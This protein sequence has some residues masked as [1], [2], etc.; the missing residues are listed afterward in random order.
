MTI[1]FLTFH[2]VYLN[3]HNLTVEG[4]PK[5]R[6]AHFC[7]ENSM[8]QLNPPIMKRFPIYPMSLLLIVLVVTG[9]QNPQQP[10]DLSWSPATPDIQ[11]GVVDTL[12]LDDL[13]VND[14]IYV[15]Q[16]IL[17]QSVSKVIRNL[18]AQELM[19]ASGYN[20]RVV[21]EQYAFQA[22]LP[23]DIRYVPTG[24]VVVDT[25]LP[26]PTP[27]AAG[28]SAVF[29]ANLNQSLN[30]LLYKLTM[31]INPDGMVPETDTTNNLYED[32]IFVLSQQQF[33]IQLA[34]PD[35]VQVKESG[36]A[37]QLAHSFN[38]LAASPT[39]NNVYYT[40]L[41]VQTTHGSTAASLP[42][43]G[44]ALLPLP[45]VINVN[46]SPSA[47]PVDVI[48]NMLVKITVI[49][50]DGCVLKQ[51]SARVEILHDI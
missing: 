18:S 34:T 40:N 31:I 41:K 23:S 49:S 38:I 7:L 24:N 50:P 39:I 32:Y 8:S 33:N 48:E 47:P 5:V 14:T 28:D 3:A 2:F 16:G 22:N 27:I 1:L 37:N 46:V 17:L 45:A 25:L 15:L 29:T 43:P 30:C 19:S 35:P 9:C 42:L 6:S 36:G 26:G 12:I 13:G 11:P 51:K 21:L 4:L 10:V 44:P 20:V